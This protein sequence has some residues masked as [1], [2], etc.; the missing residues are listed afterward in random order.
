[1]TN[2]QEYKF[3]FS[4]KFQRELTWDEKVE[5]G[6]AMAYMAQKYLQDFIDVDEGRAVS[7]V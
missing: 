7:G 3:H 5:M 4:Y 2:E 6:K 1:M